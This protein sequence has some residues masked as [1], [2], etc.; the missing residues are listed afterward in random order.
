MVKP[1]EGYLGNANLKAVGVE[2]EF[3]KDQV[4]EYQRCFSDPLHFIKNHVKIV[5]LDHGLVT[6]KPWDF[7]ENL[8]EKVHDNRFIICKFPRQTGKSTTVISYLLHYV[9]FNS[10]VRVAIL[11]NKQQTAHELLHRLKLA[12]EHLPKWLQQGVVEWNKG[13]IVLENGAKI[14]ASATSSSAVRGGSFNMIF[15]DEFAYVP[16]GVAEEFFSSVYPTISSG[17]ETKVL[18]VSTPKGMNMFYKL[19]TNAINRRNEYVPI[20][21]QWNQVPGRD[22]AWKKQTIA[23]TSEEQF[24]VEFECDFIGS[25][26]TLVST[27]KL[28]NL[29]FE[30][31][32]K[33]SDD[34]LRIYE[35]PKEDRIYSMAV[36]VSRGQGL[37]YHA[38]TVVDVT[39]LPYRVVCTFK[40]NEM[41]PMVLPDL[42]SKVATEYNEAFVLVEVNDIGGQVADSLSQDLEYENVLRTASRGHRGQELSSGFQAGSK[43]GIKT[44]VSVKRIGC[45][46]FKSL[47][48]EDKLIIRD[49]N[50]IEEISTFISKKGSFQA[51]TGHHDDLVMTLV[52]LGWM[53][54]QSYF[55]ELTDSDIRKT[56]YES[57]IKQMEEDLL[58]FGFSTTEDGFGDYEV[59]SNGDVWYR[60]DDEPRF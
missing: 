52:I 41:P 2:V 36:D 58:P 39:E 10:D 20:E 15:L 56:L 22:E 23:N 31:P 42:I 24:K 4:E 46:N 29:V 51:D 7:Q 40:N 54:S 45:A 49:I 12:Y 32:I 16:H 18:I 30:D 6:F 28:K 35:F 21:V 53:M 60:S 13:S 47:I 57:Q 11:A 43:P 3:T 17:K 8:I 44:S 38:F 48:E 34:G 55:K 59:D 26:N 27:S 33:T 9:L 1:N 14:I 37:D 25:T 50:I 5:T 19:W